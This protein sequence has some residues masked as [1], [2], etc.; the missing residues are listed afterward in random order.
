MLSTTHF[1]SFVPIIMQSTSRNAANLSLPH[2]STQMT[3]STCIAL[4]QPTGQD[5]TAPEF[6]TVRTRKITRQCRRSRSHPFRNPP[7]RSRPEP[8]IP[9]GASHKH[10]SYHPPSKHSS[11]AA[12]QPCSG[13]A[14]QRPSRPAVQL[15]SDPTTQR[16]NP[17]PRRARAREP[18]TTSRPNPSSH[19]NETKAS[20]VLGVCD[21]ILLLAALVNLTNHHH[22]ASPSHSRS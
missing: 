19:K 2:P 20:G 1:L 10:C 3:S 4:K 21:V 16:I 17:P 18:N 12:T 14:V 15:S 11:R 7:S 5:S 8:G 22:I 13:P 6:G 9:S